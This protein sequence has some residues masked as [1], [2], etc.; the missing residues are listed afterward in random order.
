MSKEYKNKNSKLS[1]SV[2]MQTV[3]FIRGHD[4]RKA[5]YLK[6][7]HSQ[8]PPPDGIPKNIKKGDPTADKAIKISRLSAAIIA[9][10]NALQVIPEE[11]R[12][13]VYQSIAYGKPT[14]GYAHR[15]TW[16][17]HRASFVEAVAHKMS[18]V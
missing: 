4:D 3:Y 8:P 1:H 10:E 12:E 7:L 16:S 5:E 15:T 2:Y 11:Y 13:G 6:V 14:P 18:F 9:V 17:R